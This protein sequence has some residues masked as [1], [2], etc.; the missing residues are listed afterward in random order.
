MEKLTMNEEQRLILQAEA[1]KLFLTGKGRD[2]ICKELGISHSTFDAWRKKLGWTQAREENQ[3]KL[4]HEMG[5]DLNA[6][7]QRSLKIISA[8]ETI[9]IDK[10]NK[11][12]LDMKATDFAQLQK[13]KWDILTPKNQT[14]FNFMKQENNVQ[15][16]KEEYERLFR[17]IDFRNGQ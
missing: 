14:Q 15:I 4:R 6:E 11:K 7:K 3:A 1:Y 12:Q 8:M 10:L 9:I 13:V 5:E 16:T 2:P 17:E